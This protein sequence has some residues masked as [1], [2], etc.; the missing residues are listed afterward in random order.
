MKNWI[1]VSALLWPLFVHA[2]TQHTIT[3]APGISL[4][5]AWRLAEQNNVALLTA[6][7]E[8][9]ASEGRV[10]GARS[11]LWNNPELSGEVSSRKVPDSSIVSTATREWAAGISQPFEIAGQQGHRRAAAR[12]ELEAA[13]FQVE[14]TVRQ[15][16]ADVERRFVQVLSLQSRIANEREALQLI[17][18]TASFAEKRVA[19]GEDNRLDGNFAQVEAGRARS[20]LAALE[21]QLLQ[22]RA[23]LGEIVQWPGSTLPDAAGELDQD[24]PT[25]SLDEAV[26]LARDRA[27]LRALRARENAARSRLDLERASRYPDVTV[28]IGVA[29]EGPSDLR[30][31][32]AI[33]T[34]SVPLPLFNRN[35]TNVGQARTDL[36][37][38]QAERQAGERD[39]P[40]T[41]RTLWLREQGLRARV[42]MLRE[43]VLR[44]LEENQRLS[45]KALAEGEIGLAQMVLV[46]RQLVE[47]RRDLLDALTELRVTRISLDQATGSPASAAR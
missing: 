21:D 9:L 14:E 33:F 31:N 22:A 15:V 4:S 10:E 40:A 23:D 13:T 47:A 19:A 17:D 26:A 28:G 16:R 39:L 27:Q 2:Q 30:E 36:A 20:Q 35:A 5:E 46:T 6:R 1:L 32:V 18:S 8:L 44:R 45:R 24:S 37:R 34:V 42:Q 41:A 11:L 43:S 29:R 3:P 12:A 25:P 38:V 7:A